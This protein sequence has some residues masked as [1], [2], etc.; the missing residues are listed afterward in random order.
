MFLIQLKR[1]NRDSLK[2]IEMG[3]HKLADT[4]YRMKFDNQRQNAKRRG[5][6]FNFTYETWREWWGDDIVNRDKGKDKL[7]MARKNDIG[8]Y[9]PDNVVKML[10]QDNVREGNIGKIVGEETRQKLA[11]ISYKRWAN[12]GH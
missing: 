8:P 11:A 4:P 2:D 7:V 3:R 6:P 5:I 9:D 1:D 12:E 10:N